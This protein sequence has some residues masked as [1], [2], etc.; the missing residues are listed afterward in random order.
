MELK[1]KYRGKTKILNH[2]KITS[3]VELTAAI[4]RSFPDTPSDCVIFYYDGE[5]FIEL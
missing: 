5:D 2:K 3:L 4:H 1:A